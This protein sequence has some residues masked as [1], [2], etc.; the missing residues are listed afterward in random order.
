ME[1][2]I[3]RI[4][5]KIHKNITNITVRDLLKELNINV[6][7]VIVIKNNELVDEDEIL[8]N[9]DDVKIISVISGG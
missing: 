7:E 8:E 6:E 4:N 9:K 1:I 2:Y 5:K 3:E